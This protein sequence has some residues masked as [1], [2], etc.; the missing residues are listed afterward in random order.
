MQKPLG[1]GAKIGQA[2]ARKL[3]HQFR[4]SD[5]IMIDLIVFDKDGVILDL[6]ATW[7][8]VA[9]AVAHYTASR[10]PDD[11]DGSVGAPEL[12][13]AIGVDEEVGI[14]DPRGIFAAGSF[15]DIRDRWQKMLPPHMIRLDSDKGYAHDVGE[16]V[17]LHGRN[18]TVPKG[19]VVT[20]LRQ[21]YDAGYALAILTNDTENS[22]RKNMQDIGVLDYFCAIIGADSGYGPKP[23]PHGFFRCCEIAGV[24][25]AVSIMVGDTMAD[26]GTATAA[27]AADF[28]CVADHVDDRPH[29]DIDHAKVIGR[30]DQL[31]A[32]MAAR[33][34]G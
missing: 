13:A 2:N 30:I 9:L 18:K 19:D 5:K 11:W 14:I 29:H 24:T 23:G 16:L 28:I 34:A 3:P 25:P 10:I 22:A 20:P 8:P 27:K 1:H 21:L 15:A 26:Y 32:L 6:E 33:L 4:L 17:N 7:L 31:P 12:L